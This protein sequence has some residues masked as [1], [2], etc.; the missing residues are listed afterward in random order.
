MI[1]TPIVQTQA[2]ACRGKEGKKDTLGVWVLS[3]TVVPNQT[4]ATFCC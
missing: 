3:T 2:V 4:I 1:W